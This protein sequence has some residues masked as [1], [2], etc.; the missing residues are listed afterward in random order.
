MAFE[1]KSAKVEEVETVVETANE[2]SEVE[3]LKARIAELEAEKATPKEE[4]KTEK[5][6]KDWINERVPFFASIQPDGKNE[7]IVVGINGKNFVIQ[8][9]KQVMIPRYVFMALE[10]SHRQE[11]EAYKANQAYAEQYRNKQSKLS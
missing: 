11:V 9:G 3:A 1:K 6:V 2:I 5:N 7:D 4:P 10:D 8:R